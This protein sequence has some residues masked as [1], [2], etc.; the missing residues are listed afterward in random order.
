M[1]FW[2]I[3]NVFGEDLNQSYVSE[4]VWLSGV[5]RGEVVSVPR[6]DDGV[7]RPVLPDLNQV[8]VDEA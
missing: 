7:V 2:D 8:F 5:D 3:G 4:S 1:S 6:C